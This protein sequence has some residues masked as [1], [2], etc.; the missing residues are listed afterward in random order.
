MRNMLDR[1]LPRL[2][3]RGVNRYP[4]LQSTRVGDAGRPRGSRLAALDPGRD[5]WADGSTV[6]FTTPAAIPGCWSRPS[7]GR[8]PRGQPGGRGL[9][10]H[11]PCVLLD[12]GWWAALGS[13][14][15]DRPAGRRAGLGRGGPG[16]RP[17]R[18]W[19]SP[20]KR[21]RQS[22]RHGAGVVMFPR[23]QSRFGA[24][25]LNFGYFASS[26]SISCHVPMYR[27]ACRIRRQRSACQSGTTLRMT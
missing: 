18:L 17:S 25:R 16:A 20:R 4:Q 14:R 15:K 23:D 22:A 21:D 26:A 8:P 13:S 11:V 7:P 6:R 10:G 1:D 27:P 3:L 5:R 12:Q 2:E 19:L 9:R 24:D